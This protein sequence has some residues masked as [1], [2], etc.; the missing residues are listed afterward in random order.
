MR[1]RL[2]RYLDQQLSLYDFFAVS[3]RRGRD[4]RQLNILQK[5]AS[6]PPLKVGWK[7]GR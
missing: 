1:E 5:V 4:R 7:V 3:V 2:N 6:T